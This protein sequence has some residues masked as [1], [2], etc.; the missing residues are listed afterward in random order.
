MS[1]GPVASAAAP[2]DG[3]TGRGTSPLVWA[4][5]LALLCLAVLT[6]LAMREDPPLDLRVYT[7]GVEAM[8]AGDNVY[9]LTYTGSQLTFTYPPFAL[10]A[11]LPMAWVSQWLASALTLVVS[12]ACVALLL[13]VALGRTRVGVVVASVMLV[14]AMAA[15][16]VWLTMHFGQVNLILAALI[17]A[18]LATGRDRWWR[19]VGLGIAAGIKLSPLTFLA[20]LLLTRQWRA[21]GVAAGT[22]LATIAASFVI[23][24]GTARAF[25][26]DT[27]PAS[28]GGDPNHMSDAIAHSMPKE[29]LGN[30]SVMGFMSRWFGPDTD[31]A[32]LAWLL[33]GGVVSVAIV[34]V[35]A[36]LTLR[37]ERT[38][39]FFVASL[40][41]VVASPIA[42]THHWV[43]AIPLAVALWESA[44]RVAF[45]MRL[46]ATHLRA[47]AG[48]VALVLVAD[49]HWWAPAR[50]MQELDWN[51]MQ[52][53]VGND[54]LLTFLAVLAVLGAG[55]LRGGVTSA[56]R[57]DG[58]SPVTSAAG[59]SSASRM[60]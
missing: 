18:D 3:S 25:W 31:A 14:A 28:A 41:M 35:G 46:E 53:I 58:Q 56:W 8:L 32:T 2:G 38:L 33:V 44:P 57:A 49:A 9:N 60:R 7:G 55:V 40:A 19:G 16:P 54:Y 36:W 15:E 42:W 43:W 24:P 52:M 23:T 59:T 17:T 1:R 45:L 39:G 22:F 47:L 20:W 11:F 13:H 26:L 51:P 12:V 21:A 30:Q 6:M 50:R 10:L 34:A 48:V 4:P 37:G 29:Y 27:L 5:A